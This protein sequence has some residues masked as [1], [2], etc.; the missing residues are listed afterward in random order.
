MCMEIFMTE[1]NPEI[2]AEDLR[3]I[4]EHHNYRYY[5]LDSPEIS[6]GEYDQLMREL[7]A[8]EEAHPELIT[9]D[10][11]TQRVGASPQTSFP[12]MVHRIPLLSI[13]NAM[14]TEEVTA[15]HGRVARWLDKEDIAYCCEPKFDGL[16]VELV[17]ER[18]FFSRGGTRGDGMTGEDV[19]GNLRTIKSIPLRL[20][21]DNIPEVIEVRGE[22]VLFKAAFKELNLER[23]EKNEPLFA[24]PRNAAAGS[25]RQLDSKI[26]ASRPLVFI[27]YGVSDAA[28]VGL[29][30]QCAVLERL[31]DFGFRVNPDK[32]LCKGMR[33]VIDF[34][35]QMQAR[36][37]EIPY[38]IDGVVIKVDRVADQDVLGVK[39]RSPR[40]VVAY[41]FP[42]TQ[43][44]TI[45]NKIDVQ[46]GRTGVVTPVAILE[47][48]RVAGVTVS[49]ATLHNADEVKRKDV[50][51]GDTVIVQ[52][53]GDV[54]PEIVAPVQSKRPQDSQPFIMPDN[55]P[56]CRSPLVREGALWRC[57][58]ISCPAIIKEEVY[59][60][61]SKEAVCIDGLGRKIVNQLVDRGLIRDVS[62]LYILTRE[63]LLGLD[64]FAELSA[65]NLVSSI[66]SSKRVSLD[67]FLYALG[68]QHVGSVAAKELSSHFGSLAR[69]MGAGEDEL[70]E[71][72]GIGKE[73]AQSIRDFFS[74]EQNQMVVAKLHTHGMQVSSPVKEEKRLSALSGKKF[75]FTGTL[76]SM[77]RP[78]AKKLVEELGGQVVNSVSK[79]LDFLVAGHEPGSK[80][81]KARAMQLAILDEAAFLKL[82]EEA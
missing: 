38:E 1:Q 32:R 64:G 41:K 54:I 81:D 27:A 50:R 58:N 5:V 15:F 10:S 18:G 59:H 60:F 14:D 62:D 39:A 11:P 52:R 22:V 77:S 28:A 46:V 24:N 6:D 55:C 57:V 71:L 4:I 16:A 65:A 79:Q 63:D 72:K 30:S 73:I 33:E 45:L 68:I 69:I 78:E 12:P 67:R 44:T 37:E 61:A 66:E 26:T 42:P 19:T 49:R 9:N 13:D 31:R 29:D 36:R 8:L 20:R 43:A 74:N 70:L 82:L 51:E 35:L 21:G 34:V 17:Y 40:W 48:V 2:R 56:A 25:L 76:S 75:C 23:A 7:A 53:A 47:P 3:R 80:M